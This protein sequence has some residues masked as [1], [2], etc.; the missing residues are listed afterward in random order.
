MDN[1]EELDEEL[2]LEISNDMNSKSQLHN[3]SQPI[4]TEDGI[5]LKVS[6]ILKQNK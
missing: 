1:K 4:D 5:I 2:D 6:N 3:D